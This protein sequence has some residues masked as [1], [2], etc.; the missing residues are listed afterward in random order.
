MLPES[1][2][3][4]G[5]VRQRS[6]PR[7]GLANA[8]THSARRCA[9]ATAAEASAASAAAQINL[10]ALPLREYL[11]ASVVP[12]LLQGLRALVKERPNRPVEYLAAYLL[13]NAP[14]DEMET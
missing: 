10:Q 2:V 6:H 3:F 5:R 7:L 8:S 4:G 13:K 12:L 1:A 11:E 14:K 9:Q